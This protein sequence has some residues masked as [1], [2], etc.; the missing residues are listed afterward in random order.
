MKELDITPLNRNEINNQILA[1]EPFIRPDFDLL[2]PTGNYLDEDAQ[3]YQGKCKHF[4]EIAKQFQKYN[5]QTFVTS[6][7]KTQADYDNFVKENSANFFDHDKEETESEFI[8]QF[9]HKMNN[10]GNNGKMERRRLIRNI[11][12]KL[13]TKTE[14]ICIAPWFK[15]YNILNKFI[16]YSRSIILKNRLLTNLE[17]LKLLDR[18]QIAD[19]QKK[20]VRCRNESYAKLFEKFI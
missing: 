11:H 9:Y 8:K 15:R 16:H 20:H 2:N 6:K 10:Y 17:K 18:N 3:L 5:E 19:L 12:E 7:V 13:N 1:R 14:D 4:Y